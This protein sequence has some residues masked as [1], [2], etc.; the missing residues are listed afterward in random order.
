[1]TYTKGHGTIIHSQIKPT[2]SR[3]GGKVF[4][5]LRIKFAIVSSYLTL[6]G[7]LKDIYGVQLG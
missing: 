1:M 5:R 7:D 2:E 3:I 4:Y 6:Q